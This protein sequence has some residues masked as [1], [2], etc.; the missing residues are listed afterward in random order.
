MN[1]LELQF[2]YKPDSNTGISSRLEK[3]CKDKEEL[4]KLV[5][6]VQSADNFVL[7]KVQEAVLE[8]LTESFMTERTT[9]DELLIQKGECKAYK[10]VLM[11]LP[12]SSSK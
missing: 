6:K 7:Q 2:K 8:L 3:V 4:D 5:T 12:N 11:L 10:K 9:A 1:D